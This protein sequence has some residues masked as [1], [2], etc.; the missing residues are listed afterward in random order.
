VLGITM[1]HE[2]GHLLI[3]QGHSAEGIMRAKLTEKDWQLA[4]RGQLRFHPKEEEIIRKGMRA[5]S[6]QLGIQ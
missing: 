6:R 4:C 2:I 1:A 3:S 5:R